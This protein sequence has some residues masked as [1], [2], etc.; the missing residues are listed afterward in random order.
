MKR[1]SQ[2]KTQKEDY[3]AKNIDFAMFP[4]MDESTS[5]ITY[6]EDGDDL[7]ASYFRST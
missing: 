7:A 4:S 3:R 2:Q 6:L 5:E 1:L